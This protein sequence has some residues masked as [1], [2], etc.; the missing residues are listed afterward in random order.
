MPSVHYGQAQPRGCSSPLYCTY[1]QFRLSQHNF[2]IKR[3]SKKNRTLTR[4]Y[5]SMFYLIRRTVFHLDIPHTNKKKMSSSELQPLTEEVIKDLV[6]KSKDAKKYAHA[7]YSKF[8][9]GAALLTQSGQIFTGIYKNIGLCTNCRS[10]R[11][12]SIR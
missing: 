3:K 6:A 9:V 4:V 2:L 5:C 12:V 10:V 1:A 11:C 8:P 7:P